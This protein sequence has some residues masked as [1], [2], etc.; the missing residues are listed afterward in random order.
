MSTLFVT[1]LLKN[2]NPIDDST[3]AYNMSV[4]RKVLG[5]DYTI[6]GIDIDKTNSTMIASEMIRAKYHACLV[7]FARIKF[8]LTR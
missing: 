6:F 7:D 3:H 5:T 8:Y 1:S 2:I 4:I